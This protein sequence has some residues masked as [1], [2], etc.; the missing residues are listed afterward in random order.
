MNNS[1]RRFVRMDS[2]NLLDYV[3]VDAKG[4]IL[5]HAMGRTLNISEKGILLE[6]HMQ[7]EPGQILLITIGLEEDLVDIKGQVK[8]AESRDDATFSAGI[9]FLEIDGEGSRVLQNYLE[10]FEAFAG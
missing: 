5:G 7:F 6:T 3:L 2:L 9:E 10:A 8:H 1:Q 4:E